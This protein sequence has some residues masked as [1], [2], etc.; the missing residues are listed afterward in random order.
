MPVEHSP[1][2]TLYRRLALAASALVIG[3]I[4]LGGVVRIT[5]SGLGCGDHWP[6]CDGQWFPP[7]DLP[8]LIE[9]SHRWVA[10]LV[11]VAVFALFAVA[12]RRHRKQREL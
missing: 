9:I 7:L 1:G 8:T 5:G 12:W 4:T 3:L 6:L 10:A 2:P 11:T